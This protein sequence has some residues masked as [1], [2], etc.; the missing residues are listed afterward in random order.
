MATTA[1]GLTIP[2][3]SPTTTEA[4]PI[5]DHWNNLGTSLNGRIIVPVADVTARAAL[6]VALTAE[7]YTISASNPLYTHRA[8]ATVGSELEVTVNGTSWK[9]ANTSDTGWVPFTYANG[10]SGFV[11]DGEPEAGYRLQDGVM[12]LRGAVTG[13]A[14]Q[15]AIAILPAGS[16]GYQQFLVTVRGSASVCA[17]AAYATGNITPNGYTTG[18]VLFLD[19][20]AFMVA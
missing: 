20:I 8:D 3:T 17:V 11:D 13:G 14:N 16:T 18:W 9:A 15:T 5:Q 10:W 7:G 4:T 19:N 1:S 12:R 6:V 2:G